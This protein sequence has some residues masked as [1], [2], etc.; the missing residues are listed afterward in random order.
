[1]VS[2]VACKSR[3]KWFMSFTNIQVLLHY[4][5][6]PSFSLA[7]TQTMLALVVVIK[8]SRLMTW[9]TSCGNRVFSTSQLAM[10]LTTT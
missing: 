5:Y 2:D 7:L 8:C 4:L 1:M 3:N 9:E 6:V 10:L